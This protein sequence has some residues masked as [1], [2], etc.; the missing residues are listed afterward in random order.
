MFGESVY[1][2][3]QVIAVNERSMRILAKEKKQEVEKLIFLKNILS[4]ES[5]VM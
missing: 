2:N 4:I 5:E 1:K 3:C